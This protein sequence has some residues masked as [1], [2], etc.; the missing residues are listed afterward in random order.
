ME[1]IAEVG[2]GKQESALLG[3]VV[4]VGKHRRA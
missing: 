3:N 1:L 2:T 4:S